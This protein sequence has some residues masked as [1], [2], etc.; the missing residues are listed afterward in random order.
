MLVLRTPIAPKEREKKVKAD[1]TRWML[2]SGQPGRNRGDEF[3]EEKDRETISGTHA[4]IGHLAISS[5][6]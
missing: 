4:V 1:L 3:S 5:S 2:F 6:A